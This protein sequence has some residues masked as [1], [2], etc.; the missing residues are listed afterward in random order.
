MGRGGAGVLDLVL[1]AV[2][3]LTACLV[4]NLD[5]GFLFNAGRAFIFTTGFFF[6]AGFVF[7]FVLFF[8]AGEAFFLTAWA[9]FSR[10]FS[11][12]SVALS[13]KAFRRRTVSRKSGL[14]LGINS[15]AYLSFFTIWAR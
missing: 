10:I 13:C 2:L 11:S 3:F 5:A 14:F 1:T 7:G 8:K 12:F 15:Q 4:V 6:N 9:S